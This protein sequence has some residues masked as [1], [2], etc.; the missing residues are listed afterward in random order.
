MLRNSIGDMG[1]RRMKKRRGKL[2]RDEERRFFRDVCESLIW[3]LLHEVGR[4]GDMIAINTV[5]SE[6]CVLKRVE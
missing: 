6:V 1:G 5:K 4:R 3:A 2:K